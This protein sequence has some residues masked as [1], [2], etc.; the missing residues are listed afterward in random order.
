MPNRSKNCDQSSSVHRQIIFI[1]I[2]PQ[3]IRSIKEINIDNTPL[4]GNVLV[5]VSV[6]Y[7]KIKP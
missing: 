7:F 3:K 4:L 6:T 2:A 5:C 1:P